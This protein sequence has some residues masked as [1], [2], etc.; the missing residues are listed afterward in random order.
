MKGLSGR[1]I[2]QVAQLIQPLL[3]RQARRR[4]ADQQV[5]PTAVEI[6]TRACR[7]DVPSGCPTWPADR[8]L[9]PT[10]SSATIARATSAGANDAAAGRCVLDITGAFAATLL[11]LLIAR[12]FQAQRVPVRRRGRPRCGIRLLPVLLRTET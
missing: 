3:Q 5:V 6:S 10:T 8:V 9:D 12:L 7:N 2:A 1:D 11:S 4:I